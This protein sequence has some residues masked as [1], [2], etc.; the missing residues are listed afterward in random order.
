MKNHPIYD[1]LKAKAD[2]DGRAPYFDTADVAKCIRSTLAKSWPKTKFSAKI[3]RYAGGS[4]VQVSWVD[5]PTDAMVSAITDRFEG[6]GFD[7]MIDMA[8]YK[9]VFLMPDGS[10]EFAQ[11]NGTE[12]SMGVVPAAKA[13]KPAPEAIRVSP[14]CYIFTERSLSLEAMQ[15]ACK[16][17]AAR[18]PGCP[19][20]EAIK[21]GAVGV[22]ADPVYGGWRYFGDPYAIRDAV[23][24]GLGY[25]GDCV[26][27]Q[28]AGRRM[29]AA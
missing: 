9:D 12:G 3:S 25:G 13:W 22:E 8:Y 23:G 18:W 11:T 28:Y 1:K 10:A 2:A 7:G 17:Y 29:M 14:G 19:L 6:K 5:G 15:R 27:R 24:D 4:S 21:A 16:S 20:A 26:L